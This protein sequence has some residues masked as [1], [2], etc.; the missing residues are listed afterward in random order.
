VLASEGALQN[1]RRRALF[2]Q[3]AVQTR[4]EAVEQNR[5]QAKKEQPKC[6]N[7]R[8][9]I[10]LLLGAAREDVDLVGQHAA[11]RVDDRGLLIAEELVALVNVDEAFVRMAQHGCRDDDAPAPLKLGVLV[12]QALRFGEVL[13]LQ[14]IVNRALAS[15]E[16]CSG[17]VI[18]IDVELIVGKR[19]P[20]KNILFVD[21]QAL[22]LLDRGLYRLD[23]RLTREGLRDA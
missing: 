18:L 7:V 2:L 6:A 4:S 16:L 15:V 14:R 8:A 23:L 11:D 19:I 3:F 21:L 22:K 10:E 1:L 17:C 20:A 12:E 5:E 13:R 9:A